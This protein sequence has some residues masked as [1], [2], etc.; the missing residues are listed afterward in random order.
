MTAPR[1]WEVFNPAGTLGF[2]FAPDEL[3]AVAAIEGATGAAE[4]QARPARDD[5]ARHW[6]AHEMEAPPLGIAM[7]YGALISPDPARPTW[8]YS[9]LEGA[10]LVHGPTDAPV[11][12]WIDDEDDEGEDEPLD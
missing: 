10:W 6:K 2:A 8:V 1:L 7:G 12:V 3:A 11:G 4:I 9:D 5:E